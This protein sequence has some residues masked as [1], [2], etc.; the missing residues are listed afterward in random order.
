MDEPTTASNGAGKKRGPKPG[1]HDRQ[2]RKR[3]EIKPV[4]AELL[5]QP[6][7]AVNVDPI[8]LELEADTVAHEAAADAAQI[9]A[10]LPPSP[11]AQA[12][13]VQVENAAEGYKLIATALVAQGAELW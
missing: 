8:A 5:E 13:A 7:N 2:Q 9:A 11:E 10:D 6:M 4:A 12:A 3:R 1:S